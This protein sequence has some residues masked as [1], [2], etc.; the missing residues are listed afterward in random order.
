[1]REEPA[2]RSGATSARGGSVSPS[3]AISGRAAVES[4]RERREM[5]ELVLEVAW[6]RERVAD[7]GRHEITQRA[8][9]MT[10]T[11]VDVVPLETELRGARVV[12]GKLLS[13]LVTLEDLPIV[14]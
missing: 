7:A 14:D 3:G 6:I 5:P 2:G 10:E 13:Q 4:L 1:M 9:R 8:S 12:R 11:V